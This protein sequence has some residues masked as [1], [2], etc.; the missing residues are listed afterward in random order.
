[1]TEDWY[2]DELPWLGPPSQLPPR[3]ERARPAPAQPR[4]A[5]GTAA[6]PASS[7]ADRVPAW[8]LEGA[9]PPFVRIR[10]RRYGE[11]VALKWAGVLLVLLAVLTAFALIVRDIRSGSN[12]TPVP[13]AQL[14][15]PAATGPSTEQPASI[16]ANPAFQGKVICLDAA[17]GGFDRGFRRTGDATAPAMDEALYTVAYTRELAG[18]LTAMGFTVI[19]TRDGDALRNADFQDINRDGQTRESA[20]TEADAA[21][22]AL[23]DEMQARVDYCNDERADL[24][25]SI[26]FDGEQ[27]PSK[28]GFSIWYAEGRDDSAASLQLAQLLNQQLT[29]EFAAAGYPVVDGGIQPESRA[30]TH[31]NQMLYDS[32]FM[33]TGARDGLK[34]PSRMPGVVA[35]L[36]TISNAS[37]A[38]ILASETGRETIV[39]SLAEAIGQYFTEPA[40]QG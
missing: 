39:R 19:T 21:H 26:H 40:A 23:L 33:I 6:V 10:Q 17:H 1:M 30:A 16:A 34:D 35:D 7:P 37:D 15:I 27:D 25:I 32:L 12:E 13:T 5:A 24:L 20:A 11:V 18:Q 8:V 14:V 31:G 4:R 29:A 2:E 38:R 22:N 36:L 3:R 9:V 28:S